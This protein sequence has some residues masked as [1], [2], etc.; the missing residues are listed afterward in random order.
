M[1]YGVVEYHGS[2]FLII[3]LR[4]KSFDITGRGFFKSYSL[5]EG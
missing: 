2:H 5:K 3:L 1:G 4:R